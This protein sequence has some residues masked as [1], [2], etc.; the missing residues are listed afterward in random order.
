ME[1]NYFTVSETITK[2]LSQMDAQNHQRDLTDEELVR[3]LIEDEIKKLENQADPISLAKAMFDYKLERDCSF[4]VFIPANYNAPFKIYNP[5]KNGM[6][7]EKIQIGSA[8][9]S[10]QYSVLVFNKNNN[11]TDGFLISS[12]AYVTQQ[13]AYNCYAKWFDTIG[14]I[15]IINPISNTI[16]TPP[17]AYSNGADTIV[18]IIGYEISKG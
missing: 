15:N 1:H 12:N 3:E 5:C 9:P 8:D 18:N 11:F 2:K 13:S 17:I 16:T 7:V 14:Y 10:G 4:N 6:F